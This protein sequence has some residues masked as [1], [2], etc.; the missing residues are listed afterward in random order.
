MMTKRLLS[1][2]FLTAGVFAFSACGGGNDCDKAADEFESCRAALDCSGKTGVD[3]ATCEAV[4]M[5]TT[6]TSSDAPACEGATL[7]AATACLGRFTQ[8]NNC[9]CGG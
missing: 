2:L 1:A 4:K 8:E 6:N 9:I 3:Q 7:T 5:S